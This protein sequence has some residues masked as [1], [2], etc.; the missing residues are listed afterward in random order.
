M[1]DCGVE[2]LFG[3]LYRVL[4]SI[5]DGGSVLAVLLTHGHADHAGAGS[6]FQRLGVPVYAHPEDWPMIECGNDYPGVPGFL[7]YTGYTP[8]QTL[9]NGMEIYGLKVFSTPGHTPGSVCFYD[10][11]RGI[12]FTGD[13]TICKPSD[14][15]SSEDLT[16]ELE[17]AT[18]LT[19]TGE[20]L[21]RQEDSLRFLL[22]LEASAILPGHSRSYYGSLNVKIYLWYSLTLV[23]L[24]ESMK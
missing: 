8:N 17:F 19:L 18:M 9:N 3:E 7:T 12:L 20:Q 11:R 2:E 24:A 22:G 15:V 4:K 5:S 13:T 6:K 14:D 1:I 10:E 16:F 23:K 21:E